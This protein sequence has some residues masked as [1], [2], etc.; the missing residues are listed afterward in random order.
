[1]FRVK[2]STLAFAVAALCA[3]GALAQTTGTTN[4]TVTRTTSYPPVGL[5][6]SETAQVNVV[7]TA[8]NAQ[9]G[10]AASCTGSVSFYNSAGAAIGA[11]RPFTVTSGQIFSTA[12]PFTSAGASTTRTTIR[13]VVSLTFNPSTAAP[14]SL[15]STFETFDTNLG[16]THVHIG[17]EAGGLAIG[18]R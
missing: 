17:A 12:L 9:N 7:N 1:M 6:S 16:A 15:A 5:A 14:C 3:A 4:N 10:T 8:S 11:A 18:R 13:A 2:P